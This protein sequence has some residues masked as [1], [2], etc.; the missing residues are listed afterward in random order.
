MSE[1]S[2]IHPENIWRKLGLQAGQSVIHLGSGPGFFLVPAAKL[3]GENGKAVG[4]EIRS[5][6]LSEMEGRAK[7]ENVSNVVK[8]IRADLEQEKGSGLQQ[9]SFDW[10]LIANI[11]HQAQP[12]AIIKEA[13]RL[14]KD[15]GSVVVVEW[16]TVATPLGPPA[17]QRITQEKVEEMAT[18]FS[19][20]TEKKLK[21]S[22]YHYGIVFKK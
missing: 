17:E 10:V 4:V 8:S 14:V 9:A 7:R 6:M 3:I 19:L 22:P 15:T 12:E 11:L 1:A 21:P 2:F 13:A 18:Q 16:D 20:K 5:D